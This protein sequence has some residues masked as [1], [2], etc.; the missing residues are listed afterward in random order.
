[1][2]AKKHGRNLQSLKGVKSALAYVIWRVIKRQYSIL[3]PIYVLFVK[4]F[5]QVM[6]I[7]PE[8]LAVR[9]DL[10]EAGIYSTPGIERSDQ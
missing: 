8:D 9:G 5:Y 10:C 7:E 1:M 2:W 3:P 4:L 6:E